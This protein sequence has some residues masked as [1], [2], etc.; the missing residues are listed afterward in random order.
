MKLSVLLISVLS[1]L[2]ASLE[3]DAFVTVSRAARRNGGRVS[4]VMKEANGYSASSGKFLK[5]AA[6]A[7]FSAI[8][9]AS[10]RPEGVNRPDLLPKGTSKP[11]VQSPAYH[12]PSTIGNLF[13]KISAFPL[14]PQA[15]SCP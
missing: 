9:I 10:A 8:Q 5:S 7:F 3:T 6:I 14:P 2:F 1:F 4:V 12:G 13:T 15:T 11:T